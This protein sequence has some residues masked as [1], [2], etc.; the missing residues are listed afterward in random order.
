MGIKG[1]IYL[2]PLPALCIWLTPAATARGRG[3]FF[4]LTFCVLIDGTGLNKLAWFEENPL[5]PFRNHRTRSQRFLK[6]FFTYEP[7]VIGAT[8]ATDEQ[9]SRMETALALFLPHRVKAAAGGVDA[10]MELP[11]TANEEVRLEA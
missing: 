1:T 8:V 6:W 10:P 7:K 2:L 11:S 3:F 5:R 9:R 4:L